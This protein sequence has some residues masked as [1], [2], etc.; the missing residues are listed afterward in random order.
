M[1][2]WSIKPKKHI[3]FLCFCFVDIA[4]RCFVKLM[5]RLVT[6]LAGLGYLF[7]PHVPYHPWVTTSLWN[8]EPKS[9][10]PWFV[11]DTHFLNLAY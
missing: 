7:R 6:K 11:V 5:P 10:M 4:L 3:D 1:Y 2:V 8:V 9:L